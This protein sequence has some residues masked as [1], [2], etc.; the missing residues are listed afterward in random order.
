MRDFFNPST[1]GHQMKYP[2]TRYPDASVYGR[3]YGTD[4]FYTFLSY[5]SGVLRSGSEQPTF[6]TKHC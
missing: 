4:F 5:L 1:V 6:I 2:N 3:F